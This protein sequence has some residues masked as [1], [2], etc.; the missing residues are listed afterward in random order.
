MNFGMKWMLKCVSYFLNQICT[1]YNKIIL[2]TLCAYFDVTQQRVYF[3]LVW[4]VSPCWFPIFRL[5]VFGFFCICTVW[6]LPDPNVWC[7]FHQIANRSPYVKMMLMKIKC[8][9]FFA[10]SR[11]FVIH[12]YSNQGWVINRVPGSR[13][14]F[15]FWVASILQ[16]TSCILCDMVA[17]TGT[18]LSVI[19]NWFGFVVTGDEHKTVPDQVI[20]HLK[21]KMQHLRKAIRNVRC[22]KCYNLAKTYNLEW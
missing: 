9:V 10:S 15:S 11:L 22:I 16:S 8:K 5:A 3:V 17:N 2:C 6:F 12:V 13:C 20:Q 7:L 4:V 14:F 1:H 21:L 18:L 19:W